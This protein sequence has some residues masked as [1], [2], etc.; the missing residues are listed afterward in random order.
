M[1]RSIAL[2]GA[3]SLAPA[4]VQADVTQAVI[5]D[6]TA[7]GYTRIEVQRGGVVAQRREQQVIGF[8]HRAADRVIEGLPHG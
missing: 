8:G 7:Q 6:L 4:V 1:Y 2:I 3:L 5:D